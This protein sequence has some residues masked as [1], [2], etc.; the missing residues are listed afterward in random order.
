M[1]VDEF[2]PVYD[3]S[4]GVATVVDADI[5]TTWSALMDVDL[6]EVGRQRPLVAVLGAIR[7]LPDIAG[8]LLRGAAPSRPR[9]MRLRDLTSLS[10]DQGGWVLLGERDRDEIALGLVGKFW[11]P[12]IEFARVTSPAEFRDFQQPGFAK[13]VYA[14]SVRPLDAN[15]TLLSG[16]MRTATTDEQARRWFRLYWTLG[17]GIGAHVLVN[18]LLDVTRDMAQQAAKAARVA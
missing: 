5:A 18:G 15:R 1:L 8:Q 9:T 4:D 12:V 13:T 11:L 14:L 3:I 2:M 6:I 7:M 10:L 17:V 16:V